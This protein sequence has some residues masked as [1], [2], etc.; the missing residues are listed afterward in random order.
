MVLESYVAAP[1]ARPG[2]PRDW[3]EKCLFAAPPLARTPLTKPT[4][5]PLRPRFRHAQDGHATLFSSHATRRA[6]F[7]DRAVR[8]KLTS[9]NECAWLIAQQ[10]YVNGASADLPRQS[11]TRCATEGCLLGCR[12]ERCH[13]CALNGLTPCRSAASGELDAH[14]TSTC[15]PLVG[16]SG[17]LDRRRIEGCKTSMVGTPLELAGRIAVQ[18][19]K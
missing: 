3:P 15:P 1:D 16:C 19:L 7:A 10:P 18:F 8:A 6:C 14:S 11:S 5:W 2:F 17:L 4:A 12:P 9:T 13:R